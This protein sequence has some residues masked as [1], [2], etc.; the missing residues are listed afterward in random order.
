M[1]SRPILKHAQQFTASSHISLS[2]SATVTEHLD[3]HHSSSSNNNCSVSLNQTSYFEEATCNDVPG[4]ST[5]M[6]IC[7][8]GLS[9]DDAKASQCLFEAD[10]DVETEL[11][12][13]RS[14]SRCSSNEIEES[15]LMG[16]DCN[17]KTTVG[18]VLKILADTAIRL[19]GDG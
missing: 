19:D 13:N 17:E 7:D 8:N 12:G 1:V 6:A 11:N 10:N 15:C 5:N 18:L 14:C 4:L 2:S 9:S 3:D 16:I